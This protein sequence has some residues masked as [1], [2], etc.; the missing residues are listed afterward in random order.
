MN[1]CTAAD[2]TLL[3][4]TSLQTTRRNMLGNLVAGFPGA[5]ILAGDG[6]RVATPEMLE[7]GGDDCLVEACAQYLTAFEAYN[8][9]GGHVECYEDPLYHKMIAIEKQID[10]IEARSFSGVAALARVALYFSGA[11]YGS[12]GFSNGPTA[13]WCERIVRDVLRLH[14]G[15]T[16]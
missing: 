15:D 14:C 13:Y 4:T 1:T 9:E 2:V 5:V 12:E 11:P 7:N 16:A 6:I 10:G 8:R 3:S